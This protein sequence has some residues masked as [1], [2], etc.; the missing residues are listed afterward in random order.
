MKTIWNL[1][2]VAFCSAFVILGMQLRAAAQ[3]SPKRPEQTA[4]SP[5]DLGKNA[6]TGDPR[7]PP[8]RGGSW[9]LVG[10]KSTSTYWGTPRE[11]KEL[12]L[13]TRERRGINWG[14]EGILISAA[15][16]FTDLKK[17]LKRTNREPEEPTLTVLVKMEVQKL[18]DG[19]RSTGNFLDM[20]CSVD[21]TS[22]SGERLGGSGIQDRHIKDPVY[23]PDKIKKEFTCGGY[24]L[25][26]YLKLG[27]D[28]TLNYQLK[29]YPP[30]GDKPVDVTYHFSYEWAGYEPSKSIPPDTGAAPSDREGQYRWAQK[31]DASVLE[32]RLI[33][34]AARLFSSPSVNAEKLSSTFADVS[35]IIADRAARANFSADDKDAASTNWSAHKNWAARQGPK[36]ALENLRQKLSAAFAYLSRSQKDLFFADVSV[37]MAKAEVSGSAN[38]AAASGQDPGSNNSRTNTSQNRPLVQPAKSVF[39]V[40]EEI[41]I[42]YYNAKGSGWDWVVIVN[43]NSTAESKGPFSSIDEQYGKRFDVNDNSLKER[44]GT[45]TFRG[46]PEG[47]YEVRYVAWYLDGMAGANKILGP[48]RFR[49]GNQ[50]SAA[51]T[52]RPGPVTNPPPSGTPGKDLTGLWKNPGGNATYRVRQIGT[53]LVWGVDATALGSYANVFHGQI[54]GDMI[55]GVWEDL[56]GSPTI[57]GGRMRL[58]VESDCR[59]VRASSVNP[60]G[61]DIWVKQNSTCDV[62]SL[63][64]R[65]NPSGTKPAETKPKVEAITDNRGRTNPP[66]A[67]ISK[68]TRPAPTVEEIPEDNSTTIAVNKAAPGSTDKAPVVEEIPESAVSNPASS[69]PRNKP[70]VVEEI[71]ESATPNV[72]S[73][74]PRAN[75]PQVEEIPETNNPPATNRTGGNSPNPSTPSE[76]NQPK[77]KPQKEKKP[78]DPNKPSIWTL[79]GGAVREAITTQPNPGPTQPS[80]PAPQT[81][82]CQVGPY[83]LFALNQPRANEQVWMRFTA[84]AGRGTGSGDWVGIFRAGETQS[85][86][87]RLVL[88]MYL[89][90]PD[91]VERFNLPAGQFDA[92]V[93][94]ASSFRATGNRSP[95]SGGI[96]LI[97]NP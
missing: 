46:L 17:T 74:R 28:F 73:N 67:S 35:V 62:A 81:S 68:T 19:S 83:S 15:V 25:G 50:V 92:Y 2:V 89:N 70:P 11:T 44:N 86:N 4:E 39:G 8:P 88:W 45:F 1:L 16:V 3:Q 23:Y 48:V 61:A 58:K 95:I 20:H 90:S 53:K 38:E 52:P 10:I 7:L 84:P 6:G 65:S 71:P 54:T 72:A 85:S 33:S 80:S 87:D 30:H 55:D 57:G 94:D 64:Q 96:R 9:D 75:P 24:R 69:K 37:A 18:D 34:N 79:L 31:Q 36:G 27:E 59:F 26:Q 41:A 5:G 76:T 66:K 91:C 43:P 21:V 14:K 97:V 82:G 60:Y 56:P 13:D 22:R 42:D 32:S 78:R 47:E 29:V 51:P 63:T 77:T 49:V 93:F 40:N 12:P